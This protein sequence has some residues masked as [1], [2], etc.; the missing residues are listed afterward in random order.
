[1]AYLRPVVGE[2]DVETI[3]GVGRQKIPVVRTP[4]MNT[5]SNV[6]S[7]S[8][9]ALSIVSRSGKVVVVMMPR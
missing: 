4:V 6:V 2:V 5:P 9:K 3:D 8:R 7:R 1:M